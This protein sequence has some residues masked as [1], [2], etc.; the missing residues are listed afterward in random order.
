MIWNHFSRC[1]LFLAIC[2][3]WGASVLG[4]GLGG[5]NRG[6]SWCWP[7]LA[8]IFV[9]L[10][11]AVPA[12]GGV[13]ASQVVVVVNADSADSRTVANYYIQ[14][15]GIPSQNVVV[16]KNIPNQ[17][18]ISVEQFRELILKP[19]LQEIDRRQMSSSIKC[20]SYSADFP[21]A[22]Q[23]DSDLNGIKDR[24]IFITPVGSI[25]GLTFLC[26]M[27]AQK[28]P[29]YV[30]LESN[31]YARRAGSH[32][33]NN[34]FSANQF[35]R[36]KAIESL[37]Q[38]KKHLE[39]AEAFEGVLVEMPN[40]FPSA[41]L[42]AEQYAQAG[43]VDAAVDMLQA[44]V[45]TGWIWRKPTENNERFTPLKKDQRY[46]ELLAKLQDKSFEFQPAIGFESRSF[47]GPNGVVSS[48]PSEGLRY[49][50]STVLAVTRGEGTTVAEAID[51]LDR[52]AAADYSF[53]EG[54]FYFTS[55]ADV[56]TTT[57]K[58]SFAMA[59]DALRT[60]GKKSEIVEGVLPQRKPDC[61][62]VMIGSADYDWSG[63][64]SRLVPGAIAENLTS[65]GGIMTPGSGQTKLTSLI[66]AGAAGSSGTV[67]E[68]YAIQAKFPHPM[69]QPFYA[70]GATLTEAFHLT[71]TGPYQLLIVGDPLCQPFA[72]VPRF[73]IAGLKP[74][75]VVVGS[76]NLTLTPAED[77]QK[78]S[79]PLLL[80]V[81]LD[82]KMMIENRF[83]NKLN[84]NP[85]D[86]SEGFHE[87][88]LI[89]TDDS[90]LQRQFEVRL[91]F[92]F[93]LEAS[94]FYFEFQ[95]EVTRVENE[96]LEVEL[97]FP[98]ADSIELRCYGEVLGMVKGAKGKVEIPTSSIGLGQL[99]LQPVAI[100][101]GKEVSGAP[102]ILTL[103]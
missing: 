5:V 32:F 33:F 68:P 38:E 73:T 74:L 20:I 90:L 92:Y 67:T 23:I 7:L 78:H 54:T 43:K 36:W 1:E 24:P 84:I 45:E 42:A 61:L 79:Q 51:N 3:K 60:L 39:A 28:N 12:S 31:L 6:K 58:P 80:Q 48:L 49:V 103:K 8:S 10:S 95:Q 56:R 93:Q 11:L 52:S 9:T 72:K 37:V 66:R 27:V 13:T 16:L 21:T 76:L 4:G 41:Y 55:T 35:S 88:A 82:G 71:V 46:H 99:P 26:Q 102:K 30:S 86:L 17:E 89:A 64:Q 47:Y 101:A 18:T 22:I 53:P 98:R 91:P 69:I 40:Q 62:G 100:V 97:G 14:R 19:L 77:R 34:P 65:L 83:V 25:N 50:M 81:L 15:R 85:G 70:D 29:Q 44:A 94:D 59:M 63:C 57:R 2:D 96:T 87:M 75:D